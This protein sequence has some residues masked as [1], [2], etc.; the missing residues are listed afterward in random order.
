MGEEKFRLP[1]ECLCPQC[2]LY[3][4]CLASTQKVFASHG[5]AAKKIVVGVD[6]VLRQQ[7]LPEEVRQ[8]ALRVIESEVKKLDPLSMGCSLLG[9][10]LG[11]LFADWLKSCLKG[12]SPRKLRRKGS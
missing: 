2:P 5:E 7:N 6:E 1:S 8:Q 9:G 11:L 10:F 12:Y 3:E 4:Q